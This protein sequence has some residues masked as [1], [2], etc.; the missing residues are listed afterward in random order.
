M[1]ILFVNK[2]HSILDV[3]NW[4]FKLIYTETLLFIS[5]IYIYIYLYK[6]TRKTQ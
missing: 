1:E 5:R 4:E 6:Q 2:L 3:F